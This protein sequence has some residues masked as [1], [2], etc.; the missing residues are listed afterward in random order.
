MPVSVVYH[1]PHCHYPLGPLLRIEWA[2]IAPCPKC[3][4][5]VRRSADAF[6]G[7]CMYCFGLYAWLATLPFVTGYLL[8]VPWQPGIGT[9]ATLIVAAFVSLVVAGPIGMIAGI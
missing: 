6:A 1:C 2:E 3:L 5:H 9:A 4:R 8:L 7:N